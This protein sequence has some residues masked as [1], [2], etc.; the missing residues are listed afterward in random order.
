M[1]L[2]CMAYRQG[3]VYVAACLDLSLAAQGDNI[4]EA[5][6]KLE[7]QIEDYLEE[8]RAEPQYA[9]QMLSR[10]A[11]LSMWVKYW[12]IAFRIFMNREDRGMAKVF[13]EQCERV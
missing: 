10:K 9:K 13:N 6:N 1:R 11:P 5:I 12:R 7:A 4:E 2:R 8:V 3:E